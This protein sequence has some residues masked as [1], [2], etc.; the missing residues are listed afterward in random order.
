MEFSISTKEKLHAHC[1]ARVRARIAAAEAAMNAAQEA[2]NSETKSSMGDKYETGRAMMQLERDKAARQLS[3]N[4]KLLEVLENINPTTACEA[5][6]P[7]A[8]VES[9]LGLLYISCGLG[10]MNVDDLDFFALSPASP[11]AKAIWGLKS[12]DKTIFNSKDLNI[13]AIC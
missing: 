13:L 12:G 1:L 8:L 9:S 3:E 5:I 4:M 11:V 7:G 6:E 10:K 2:A